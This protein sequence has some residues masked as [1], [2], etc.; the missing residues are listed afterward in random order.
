M[1][2]LL[3][4]TGW[5]DDALTPRARRA[6]ARISTR[7]GTGTIMRQVARSE[8][9]AKPCSDRSRSTTVCFDSL[10]DKS[11]GDGLWQHVLSPPSLQQRCIHSMTRSWH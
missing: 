8:A 9:G 10:E 2:G 7:L 4:R 3:L 5:T 6:G 1:G 11:E